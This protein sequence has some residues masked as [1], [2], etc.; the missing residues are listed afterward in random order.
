MIPLILAETELENH[1]ISI[2]MKIF[3]NSAHQFSDARR[4]IDNQMKRNVYR[5]SKNLVW[6]LM[7]FI[8][9]VVFGENA[10]E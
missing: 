6:S 9:L 8:Q 10:A 1:G 7:D 3:A 5:N 2:L 4:N